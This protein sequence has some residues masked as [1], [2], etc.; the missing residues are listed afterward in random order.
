MKLYLH[1]ILSHGLSDNIAESLL[2]RWPLYALK[3]DIWLLQCRPVSFPPPPS[4]HVGVWP[5]VFAAFDPI[6]IITG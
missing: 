5:Q 2:V 4:L 1:G 6:D 3:I